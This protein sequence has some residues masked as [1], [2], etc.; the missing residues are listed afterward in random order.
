MIKQTVYVRNKTLRYLVMKAMYDEEGDV[1]FIRK[2]IDAVLER[3]PILQDDIEQTVPLA[4]GRLLGLE[5]PDDEDVLALRSY[6]ELWCGD[7]T[8]GLRA[9]N[10]R[11][12]G[13]AVEYGTGIMTA[14]KTA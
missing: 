4:L 8:Y 12:L 3:H 13:L 7:Y 9:L 2:K 5:A 6:V 11:D 1:A 14:M 10:M